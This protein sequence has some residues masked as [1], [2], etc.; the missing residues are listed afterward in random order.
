MEQGADDHDEGSGHDRP[1]PAK[2]LIHP[3][4]KRHGENGTEL[5][6]GRNETE[7]GRLNGPFAFGILM[8]RPEV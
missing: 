8:A 1:S 5:V 6:A 4:G 2:T 3:R 7:K